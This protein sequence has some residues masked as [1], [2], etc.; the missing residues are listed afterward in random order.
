MFY[1][2]LVWFLIYQCYSDKLPVMIHQKL[3]QLITYKRILQSNQGIDERFPLETKDREKEDK[4]LIQ[5]VKNIKKKTLLD[6]LESKQV[7][8]VTKIEE[9]EE[10]QEVDKESSK[11]KPNLF[12]GSLLEEWCDLLESMV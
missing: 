7:S 5:L 4:T 1:F 11:Y 12:A 10:R 8:I 3:K 6:R 9:I 2:I